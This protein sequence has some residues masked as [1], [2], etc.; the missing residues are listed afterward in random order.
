MC[1]QNKETS[2]NLHCEPNHEETQYTKPMSLYI[3]KHKAN[4]AYKVCYNYRYLSHTH[5]KLNH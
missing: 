2:H 4:H 5:V 1:N 3:Q